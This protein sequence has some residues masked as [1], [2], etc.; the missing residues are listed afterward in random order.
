MS[1]Q[2]TAK[3][4]QEREALESA[5]R[6]ALI[7]ALEECAGGRWGLFGQNDHT[8][9]PRL[10]ERYTPKSVSRLI[11]LAEVLRSVRRELGYSEEY[12]PLRRLREYRARREPQV[13]GEPVLAKQFLEE[14]MV[15]E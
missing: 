15:S 1:L 6:E 5:V 2:R 12:G 9:P 4:E 11:E 8:L 7:A 13:P 10:K 3:L 14:L